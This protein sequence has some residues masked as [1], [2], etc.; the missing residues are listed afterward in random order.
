M[1]GTLHSAEFRRQH[2][3]H[4]FRHC[5]DGA[6]A[7]CQGRYKYLLSDGSDMLRG[8]QHCV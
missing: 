6:P 4:S 7:V 2:Y 1:L 5:F 8:K 3:T